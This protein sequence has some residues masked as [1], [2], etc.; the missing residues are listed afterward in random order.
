MDELACFV[1]G[2]LALGSSGY[3][4]GGDKFMSLAEEVLILQKFL[5]FRHHST[6]L[7]KYWVVQLHIVQGQAVIIFW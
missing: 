7:K 5:C 6:C 4:T 2:M 3:G 1:P